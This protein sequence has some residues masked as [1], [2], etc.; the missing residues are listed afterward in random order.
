MKP[1]LFLITSLVLALALTLTACVK[2]EDLHTLQNR[3]DEQ[4]RQIQMLDSQLSQTSSQ[5]T[6][7]RPTQ[8]NLWAEIENLRVQTATMDGRVADLE[9][10]VQGDAASKEELELLKSRVAEL[11]RKLR[12]AETQL[13]LDLSQEQ[14]MGNATL[15]ATPNTGGA[16]AGQ[17]GPAVQTAQ[18]PAQALYDQALAEFNKRNY[19]N[20]QA[21]WAEFVKTFKGHPLAPNAFF[22][23]G[24]CYYQLGDYA[25]A[26]L[27][28]QEVITNYPNSI[29]YK[30]AL[31]KQ[32][33]SFYKM[34]KKTAGQLV[35]QNVVKQFPDSAE[36]KRAQEFLRSN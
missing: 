35:L 30:T 18:D 14:P 8:A 31:L 5:I 10:Q 2:E 29:K 13:A 21:I 33:V 28:Y 24:E 6:D 23:Q 25:R 22:W 20:A 4:D 36:A 27:A 9:R 26:I 32:G 1:R 7:V 3:V 17:P 12:K 16:P 34:D 19:E 11:E 15:A